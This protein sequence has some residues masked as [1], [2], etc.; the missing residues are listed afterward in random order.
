MRPLSAVE[1]NFRPLLQPCSLLRDR[2]WFPS[3]RKQTPWRHRKIWHSNTRLF[4]CIRAAS[5]SSLSVCRNLRSFVIICCYII[6]LIR[7]MVG[8]NILVVLLCLT[9]QSGLIT[10]PDVSDNRQ[11][12]SG[13]GNFFRNSCFTGRFFVKRGG[14]PQKSPEGGARAAVPE[15]PGK[16]PCI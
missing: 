7:L 15:P 16:L 5:S 12:R 9:G 8:A 4:S 2:A 1:E 3:L 14:V 10:G 13:R 6:E 11:P